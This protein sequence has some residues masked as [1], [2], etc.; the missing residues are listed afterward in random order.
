MQQEVL[1]V[2]FTE[3]SVHFFPKRRYFQKDYT[4][5]ETRKLS[6]AYLQI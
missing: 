2:H 5:Q 3:T 1:S 6:D 4:L